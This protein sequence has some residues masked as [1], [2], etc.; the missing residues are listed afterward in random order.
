MP[1]T[2]TTALAIAASITMLLP[3]AA[4]A[5]DIDGVHD[6]RSALAVAIAVPPPTTY[7]AYLVPYMRGGTC[8]RPS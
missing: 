3:L 7:P 4:R 8:P 6:D 5:A 2:R 1:R